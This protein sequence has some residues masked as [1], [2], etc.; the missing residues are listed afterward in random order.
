MQKNYL[1]NIKNKLLFFKLF[2]KYDWVSIFIS[3]Y[4]IKI[5][6]AV[7][8]PGEL[9]QLWALI[10]SLKRPQIIL[11]IG[12]AFGGN[13]FFF[14]KLAT[15]NALFISIDLPPKNLSNFE[16]V[17]NMTTSD[18]HS[19]NLKNT[20]TLFSIRED[21]QSQE[22]LKKVIDLLNGRKIDLLY[23][24]GDH[25]FEGISKDFHLYSRLVRKGGLIIFHDI[26]EY[27]QKPSVGV[28]KKWLSI[29]TKY[30]STYE[31]FDDSPIS[32]WGGIGVLVI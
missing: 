12:T 1:K 6:K 15:K 28:R 19:K 29:K 16:E 13:L 18:F 14:S 17:K 7:Q 24:D 8:K 10:K 22:S 21:S 32:E 3:F 9:C 27:I 23:L 11:E 25:S 5:K 20:Q 26:R 30:K 2:F 31:L 4:S